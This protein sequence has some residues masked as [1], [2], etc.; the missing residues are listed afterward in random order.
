[1]I[2]ARRD[3]ADREDLARA[4]AEE[5]AAALHAAIE[6]KGEAVL[7]VSGG[8]TPVLFFD[9][10]SKMDIAWSSVTIT[11]VDER[12]V[13]E[14]SERSNA[15]L[16]RRHLLQNRAA[17]AKFVPLFENAGASGPASIDV[18]IL[19]MGADGHTAS[20]FP[21]GDKLREALDPH[22]KRRLVE[23]VA[24]AAGEP[25]ITFAL[26][27]LLEAGRR[28]LHIEGEEKRRVLDRAMR[29]GPVE[30]MPI[31]AVLRAKEALT[32]YW[33]P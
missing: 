23:M 29:E 15:R 13:P 19:G 18:A 20:F 16:V 3:F 1:M 26:P 28:I 12:L 14:T 21:G 9:R 25:R 22:A 10:L 31:R 6:S 27:A 24:P 4:L 8:T 7:A 5:V 30:E 17:A 11:L 32:I 33:S 2:A